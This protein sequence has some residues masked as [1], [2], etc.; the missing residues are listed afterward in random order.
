MKK[1]YMAL[2]LSVVLVGCFAGVASAVDITAKGLWQFGFGVNN[3]YLSETNRL[4][5]KKPATD[6]FNGRQRIRTQ[7]DFTASENLGGTL[8][9]EIGHVNYGQA[10]HGMSL[11]GDGTTVKVRNAYLDWRVPDMD[12]KVRMGLQN[13]WLPSAAGGG[14][15]LDNADVAGVAANFRWSDTVGLTAMWMRPGNDNF[16][17]ESHD[18]IAN[19]RQNYQDNIDLFLLSL[20][21]TYDGVSVTPWA[22]YGMQGKNAWRDGASGVKSYWTDINAFFPLGTDPFGYSNQAFARKSTDKV[23]GGM[24]WAGLPIK[25][26]ALAPWNAELD[27]NYGRVEAMGRYDMSKRGTP[28][29][30]RASTERQGF[31]AK[32][33]VEYKLTW[34]TPGIF[35][36]YG[37]GDDGNMKN[38]SERMPSLSP[39]ATFTGMLGDSTFYDGTPGTWD[40]ALSYAGT[41][42][43]GFHLKDM[44]FMEQL[45]HT[46]RVAYRGGTNSPAM[47]NY[48][49][50]PLDWTAG[51]QNTDGPYLTT[52]DGLLEFNL[53]NKYKIYDNLTAGL[54]LGYIVN[55]VDKGT[56]DRPWM[57][58]GMRDSGISFSRRDAWKA[59]VAFVYSF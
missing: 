24:F 26:T 32:A 33:L 13:T 57:H 34:G 19:Y 18:G 47:V 43:L 36:W 2:V 48:A 39:F 51:Q 10:A 40:M 7:F 58:E 5:G 52:H 53:Q 25:V 29:S 30:V 12:L 38:G 28:Q 46:F 35:G 37:S 23:Y 17:G 14:M 22:M 4:T 16:N 55:M 49:R 3:R 56:W 1:N 21:L 54:E 15:V 9:F 59:N 42:G 27:I 8:W 45:T 50:N 6:T 44:S 31:I 11:G 41:W 20:P